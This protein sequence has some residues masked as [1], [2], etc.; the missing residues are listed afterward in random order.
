MQLYAERYVVRPARYAIALLL[1][2]GAAY[3]AGS[4]VAEAKEGDSYYMIVFSSQ[5]ES[6][7]P[8][9]AHT[10]ATFVRTSGD[11]GAEDAV[12]EIHT[13]SWMPR[14]LEIV[15]VRRWA[16]PGIN[17]DLPA[18]LRWAQSVNARSSMWG[19]YE[20]RKELF[21][22]AVEQ[23]ARLRSGAILYKAVDE[24]MR[25]EIASNCIHAVS[26][27]DTEV[28]VLHVG[29]QR[30]DSAS[31]EVVNHLRR[32]IIDPQQTHPWVAECI[33]LRGQ[34]LKVQTAE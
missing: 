6:N 16:E 22:R 18:T 31:Q 17:L 14:S 8:R 21:E 2:A 26:D 13:I 29:R 5:N 34:P 19:P 24:R 23:K 27:L 12:A 3:L 25:G 20:V 9:F 4:M 33:G 28:G 15:V 1:L 10:F 7:Q 30:G 32:W 11:T